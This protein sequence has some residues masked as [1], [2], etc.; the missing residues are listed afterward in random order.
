MPCVLS[1]FLPRAV[2]CWEP[3]LCLQAESQVLKHVWLTHM[4]LLV[5]LH[6]SMPLFSSISDRKLTVTLF[7]LDDSLDLAFSFL[8]VRVSACIYGP[9][10]KCSLL[11]APSYVS[12]HSPPPSLSL[13]PRAACHFS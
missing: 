2:S 5:F 9:E 7:C 6:L 1:S 12:K 13:S 4:V 11:H 8:F 3:P 10:E